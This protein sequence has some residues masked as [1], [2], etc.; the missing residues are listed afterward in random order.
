MRILIPG[1]C[2]FV[3]SEVAKVLRETLPECEIVGIDN[4]SRAGSWLNRESLLSLGVQVHHGDVRN[5]SDLNAIGRADWVVDSAANASV[6]AGVDGIASSRQLIEHNLVGTINL[7]EFCKRHSAGF[8]LLSTSR[9]YSLLP[10]ASL[11]VEV[12]EGAFVPKNIA[13]IQWVSRNGISEDFSTTPPVSLYGA[14]K[15][16]SEQLAL[17]YGHAFRFPVWINRCGVMAGAGQFGK[18]DQGIFAF[19]LHSWFEQKP[20]SYIGFGGAGHQVRDCLHPRDLAAVLI[21]QMKHGSKEP[22]SQIARVSSRVYNLSGGITSARSLA[23]VSQWC[24]NRWRLREVAAS[25][26]SRPFDL[27]WVVLDSSRA[28]V[29]WDWRPTITIEEIMSE[30]AEFAERNPDWLAGC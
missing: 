24:S 25:G 22:N 28:E 6:M 4:L 7:L 15:V 17:E 9:V 29:D 12:H 30:I 20:L 10:L 11:D 13:E 23:Q 8:I 19:W 26:G 5:E 3:G 21:K 27:P 1:I 16:A 14:S 2:G 18:P